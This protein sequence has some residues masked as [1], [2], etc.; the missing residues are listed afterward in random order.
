MNRYKWL[1]GLALLFLHFSPVDAKCDQRIILQAVESI[2]LLADQPLHVKAR[3]D[4]GATYASLDS[5]LARRLKLDRFPLRE[6]KIRNSHGVS[7]RP[8]VRLKFKLKGQIRSAEF[9][10][11]PRQDL[12]YPVLLGRSSLQGFLVDPG[13]LSPE[14]KD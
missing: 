10:L 12:A 6:V 8:V 11:I 2:T 14:L 1:L 4:T 3:V 5:D 9:T 13:P 7:L